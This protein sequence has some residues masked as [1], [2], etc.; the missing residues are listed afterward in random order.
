M[1]AP[2]FSLFNDGALGVT[3]SPSTGWTFIRTAQASTAEAI[4]TIGVTDAANRLTF[5]NGT[6]ADGQFAPWMTGT[7][8]TTSNALTIAGRWTTDTGTNPVV[9]FDARSV[10]DAATTVRPM[11]S[12]RNANVSMLDMLPLASG[13]NSALSWRTQTTDVPTFSTRSAGNRLILRDEIGASAVDSA[14][15]CR[16]VGPWFSVPQA[17]SSW[18]FTWYGGQT[19]IATL[20]GDG[21]LTINGGSAPGLIV[22]AAGSTITQ[23]RTYSQALD[24]ASVAALTTAEQTFTVT[25]LATTD[26]V[27]VN[28]PS[29]TAGLGIVNAR[30]SAADTLAITFMNC[31]ASPIDAASETYTITAIRS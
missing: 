30:V 2:A 15:G 18:Q 1:K 6:T 19:A 20:R 21:L 28:K 23:F 25:G 22:G 26:K 13:A 16:G 5:S 29:N 3:G 11:F 10:A 27:F 14:I 24:P 4:V 12:F 7:G 8:L 31:T 17:T 9:I